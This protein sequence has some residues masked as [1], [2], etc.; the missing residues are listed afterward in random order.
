M[1][2][3]K[4]N[5]FG[6]KERKYLLAL[7]RRSIEHYLKARSM[8]DIKPADVPE[9]KLIENGACFVTL[10]I[11]ENNRLRGCVGSLEAHRP[12]VFDVADNAISAAFRD[13]RFY[14]VREDELKSI[15]IEI[16]ILSKPEP[17]SVETP[18]ELLKFLEPRR[19]GLIIQ[20]GWARAT[21]LPVVWDELPDKEQFLNSLCTKAGLLPNAWK[22]VQGMEF[23]VYEAEEFGEKQF[24]EE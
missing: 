7:A 12:L 23:F 15:H 11:G 17:L 19:H 20:K 21:F 22:D 1:N 3:S 13:T 5:R 2:A 18:E 10:T 9:K 24:G 6:P 16:S 14:P 8:I 4:Q